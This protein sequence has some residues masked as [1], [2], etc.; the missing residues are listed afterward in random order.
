VSLELEIKDWCDILDS[1][2]TGVVAIDRRGTIIFINTTASLLVGFPVDQALGKRVD[3]VIP[4]TRLVEVMESGR[5]EHA[6]RMVVNGH[7]V[8]SN[9]TPIKRGDE[10]V[11]AIGMFQD[12]P[13]LEELSRQLDSVRE[14]NEELD[15]LI[16]SLDDGIVVADKHGIILRVNNAYKNMV[17]ITAKE[18]VG[19]H[20]TDLVK[21]GYI[22]RSVSDLVLDRRS[23]VTIVDVRNGKELLLSGSPVFDKKG[24]VLRVVTAIRDVT[25]LNVLKERL[26]KSE[27]VRNHYYN[28]L[29]HLRRQLPFCN[30]ITHNPVMKKILDQACHVAQVDSTVLVLGESGVGKDLIARLIHRTSKR[31]R[32]PFIRINCGATPAE[33]LES[34]FFGYEPGSFTGALKDG[35]PGLFELAQGGTLFLDEVGELTPDLQVKVLRAVQEKEITRIGGRK[36]I[37]LD[38]RIISATNRDLETMVKNKSFRA[39]FFYRLNVVPL[40]IP[41]LRERKEDILPLIAEFMAAVN[42]RYGYQKWI[43]PGA[44]QYFLNHNWPGNVREL[45]NTI[46][47]AVVTC[48]E[49]CITAEVFSGLEPNVAIRCENESSSFRRKVESEERQML[50]EAYSK[51]RTTRKVAE[52]LGISQSCVV[53]KMKK[54]GIGTYE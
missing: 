8:F 25:E 30:I 12:A 19:K 24:E 28:Q 6:Q 34:E 1:V 32:Q 22:K 52:M 20:V 5:S 11:G 41:P 42:R 53:R 31:S 3:E 18:Y 43:H 15:A 21:E 48:Q 33:L 9:R 2:H 23:P 17:G 35:K 7:T 4:N 26:A 39:D 45:E 14:A 16:E 50:S 46:E 49:D 40:K 10:I 37:K 47:R 51:A 54:Y 27:R 36:P 44:M 38:V 29:E 13:R